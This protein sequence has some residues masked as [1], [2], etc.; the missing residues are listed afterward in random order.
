MKKQI[1]DEDIEYTGYRT[2][3]KCAHQFPF[4]A[5]FKRYLMSYGLSKWT[6]QK[7]GQLIKCDFIKI[8]M[9][10]LVG[11]LFSGGLFYILMP[12]L[13]LSL[14]NI[15]VIILYLCFVLSTLFYAKFEKHKS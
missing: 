11:L 13:E 2:C 1:L 5:F 6:C 14:L 15:V 9:I 4:F 8:Q 10:W 12:Y 7:C 3:P